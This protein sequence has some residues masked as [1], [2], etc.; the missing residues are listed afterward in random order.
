[1]PAKHYLRLPIIQQWA[2][3]YY[4]H[5]AHEAGFSPFT[6]EAYRGDLDLFFRFLRAQGLDIAP[7]NVHKN[8]VSDFVKDCKERL[9]HRPAS[10]ARRL[11]T[12][13][14]FF[15]YLCDENALKVNPLADL[16]RPKVPRALPKVISHQDV[17]KLFEAAKARG[18]RGREEA[19]LVELLYGSGLRIQEAC[20]ARWQDL[21]LA[22]PEG[23]SLR[24]IGKGSRMRMV[25]VTPQLKDQLARLSRGHAPQGAAF[26]LRDA[27]R[28]AFSTRLARNRVARLG[29]AAGLG[30]HLHPHMLRHAFA[31]QMLEHGADLRVI[32]E[33][34]GHAS[35]SST[36]IYT[37]VSHGR[38]WSSHRL[39]HPRV[40]ELEMT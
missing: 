19:V 30:V 35:L 3:R 22:H 4:D 13:R 32:Q 16:R 33:L 25:A 20:A 37:H 12:L 36:E 40:L 5:I 27:G 31:T 21:D 23:P 34:L 29:Q 11:S 24:V 8:L 1:M 9:Q 26:L 14:C 2:E 15:R 17:L 39:S 18:R 28:R 38:T 6:V 10:I 7:Q